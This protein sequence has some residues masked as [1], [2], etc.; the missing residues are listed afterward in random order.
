MSPKWTL[1]ELALVAVWVVVHRW[2]GEH[3]APSTLVGVTVLG[4][5]DQLVEAVAVLS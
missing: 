4:C 1:D 2:F 5:Q 3:D